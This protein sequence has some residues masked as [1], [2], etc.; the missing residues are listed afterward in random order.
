MN[1]DFKFVT[2]TF[3]ALYATEQGQRIWRYLN[4]ETSVIRMM[5]VSDVGKP[6]LLAVESRLI[7]DFGVFERENVT[8]ENKAQFDRLK[9]MIGAMVRQI[10]EYYGYKLH[11][12]N[13]KVP[14]SKVFYSASL[15]KK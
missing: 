9:Q 8:E 3:G 14:S 11:S 5:A 10:L 2:K 4:E 15:Y 7:S 6:A 12:N 1:A 13:V